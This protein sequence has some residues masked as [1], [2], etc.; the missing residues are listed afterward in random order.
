MQYFYDGIEKKWAMEMFDVRWADT[1]TL[2]GSRAGSAAPACTRCGMTCST[3]ISRCTAPRRPASSAILA[4]TL[5]PVLMGYLI[6]GRI[7]EERKNPL[8][9][10]L[11]ALPF[12][13]IGGFW[14]LYLLGHSSPS[15]RPKRCSMPSTTAPCSAL[16]RG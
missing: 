2:G 8:N 13:L 3:G 10:L 9:R 14:T 4:V 12:A 11:N 1:A 16:P 5:I 15:I 6:R 7:P